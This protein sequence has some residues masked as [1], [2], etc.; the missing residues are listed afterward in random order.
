[1]TPEEKYYWELSE[2]YIAQYENHMDRENK[3][4]IAKGVTTEMVSDLIEWRK[5]NSSNERFEKQWNRLL[6][7]E[8]ALDTFGSLSSTNIQIKRILSQHR[9][10]ISALEEQNAELK[11]QIDVLTKTIEHEQ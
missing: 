1:M 3:L 8:Q 11:K 7:I 4:M 10:K 5:K 6:L 9:Q 2:I